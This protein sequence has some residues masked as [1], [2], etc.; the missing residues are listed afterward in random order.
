[1]LSPIEHNYLVLYCVI[2]RNGSDDEKYEA[3][4]NLGDST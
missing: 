2:E 3:Y 1:M 4:K